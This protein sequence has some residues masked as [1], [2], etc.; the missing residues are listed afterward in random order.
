MSGGPLSSYTILE[1]GH[2]LAG[3]YCGLILADLGAE[4]IKIEAPGG[5][6]GRTT[7][8]HQVGQHNAYFASLNRNKRGVVI[9]L[10][11]PKGQAEFHGLCGTAHALVTNLRPAA[12]RKLGLHY[13]ALSATNPRLAC[14]ALTGFGLDS[15]W[16]DRPAYDYVVQAMTGIMELT[17]EPGAWPTKTGYSAVDNSAGA[18]AAIGLLSQLLSGKGGQVDVAMYDV[19]LSQLN[20]IASALLNGNEGA[21]RYGSSAHPYF[22]PAQVFKTRDRWLVL[23]ITHD[24]FWRLF[25]EEIG[26]PAWITHTLF[27][28]VDARSRNRSAVVD[29]VAEVLAQ[30]D[31][32][33]WLDRLVPLGVVVAGVHTLEEAL[34]SEQTVARSMVI[35]IPTPDGPLRLIGNPVKVSGITETF[36]PPPL[37]AGGSSIGQSPTRHDA[38]GA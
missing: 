1:V 37:L 34:A 15:P 17:G 2:M 31:T 30:Q 23:F 16:A 26:R 20:Y 3:P 24:G 7:G 14:V 13:S 35:E 6:I 28:T 21:Q 27:D 10:A 12:I 33:T 9:D 38:A 4:V 8:R 19:M 11:S 18:F 5:D 32:Q 36:R 29:A 25:C 22:V